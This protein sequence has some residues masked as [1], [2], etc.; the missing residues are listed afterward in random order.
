MSALLNLHICQGA[1]TLAVSRPQHWRRLWG[2]EEGRRWGGGEE[3]GMGVEV[4]AV[5]QNKVVQ[6]PV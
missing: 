4:E 1:S 5:G 6:G 3:M 2:V